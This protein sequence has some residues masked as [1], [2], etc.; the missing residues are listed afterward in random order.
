[1][2]S[3]K[4]IKMKPTN[5]NIYFDVSAFAS[6]KPSGVVYAAA[7]I[8]WGVAKRTNSKIILI[9]TRDTSNIPAKLTALPNV[10]VKKLPC[11]ARML[12][13]ISRLP[14]MLPLDTLFGKGTYVFL[15]FYNFPVTSKSITFIYDISFLLYP[16]T[17]QPKN[18]KFIKGNYQKWVK[19]SDII[20]T[21]TET[22]K[23][24]IIENLHIEAG[25]T[26][27]VPVPISEEF[28]RSD[29]S[30]IQTAKS[31]YKLPDKY[32]LFLGNIEP[33]KNLEKLVAA[34][35]KTATSKSGTSL[36]IVGA[37]TWKA[38]PI[39][40]AIDNARQHGTNIVMPSEFVRNEDLPSVI[41]GA[42]FLVQPSL[43]EGFGVP[44]T[45]ALACQTPVLVSDIPVMHEVM[46]DAAQYMNPEDVEDM[47]AQI[48]KMSKL[49]A[50]PNFQ[51]QLAQLSKNVLQKLQ[52]VEA[53]KA[54]TAVTL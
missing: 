6:S 51:N 13:M 20:A 42:E 30:Q 41:S 26:I 38:Q 21:L 5:P 22:S 43:H 36:L 2:R 44:P 35:A 49:V 48:D 54:L 14:I 24:E 17:I 25:K 18:L 4:F 47:A 11:S 27:V 7:N 8:I 31:R 33:R 12:R 10:T 29:T 15:N 28:K 37:D 39:E 3:A 34:Y 53:V 19:R 40:S 45:Q 1:M 23:R 46:G 32:V 16:E 9:G 50:D 52:P